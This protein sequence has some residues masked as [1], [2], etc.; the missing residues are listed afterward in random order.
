MANNHSAQIFLRETESGRQIAVC[1]NGKLWQLAHHQKN[2]DNPYSIGSIFKIKTLK[3]LDSKNSIC[4]LGGHSGFLEASGRA[5]PEGAMLIAQIRRE[6][7]QDKD[8]TLTPI[9]SFNSRYLIYKPGAAAVEAADARLSIKD[10]QELTGEL[11]Q[12]GWTGIVKSPSIHADTRDIVKIARQQIDSWKKINVSY[13]ALP[14]PGLL[15]AGAGHIE[16]ML[17]DIGRIES[18]FV[19][20]PLHAR[21]LQN[22]LQDSMPDLLDK[23]QVV[24]DPDVFLQNDI[25]DQW[26]KAVGNEWIMPN[27]VRLRFDETQTLTAIDIDSSGADGDPV[28]INKS[29]CPEI[30]RLIALRNIGGIIVIDFLKMSNPSDRSA[31]SAHLQAA[32]ERDALNPKILGF[33]KTGLCEITRPRRG[34]KLPRP[35]DNK[36][37]T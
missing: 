18:I 12:I 16:K 13:A 29:V 8:P 15:A 28:S 3:N 35:C 26:H 30:S 17:M 24:S 37:L 10:L 23:V 6:S 36:D 14:G 1:Y 9:I 20:T 32:M 5:A 22:M 2:N 7:L 21:N 11:N 34:S 27:G 4:D 33:T 25:I 31:V 19:S